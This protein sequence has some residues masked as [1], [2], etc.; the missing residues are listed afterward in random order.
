LAIPIINKQRFECPSEHLDQLKRVI[1]TTEKIL[2][3]GWRGAEKH[4]L[5]LIK[6]NVAREIEVEAVCAATKIT[7]RSL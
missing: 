7:R 1:G 6:S 5:D 4:F 2:V 3:V